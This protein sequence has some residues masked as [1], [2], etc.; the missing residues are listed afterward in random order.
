MRYLD[1][2][3]FSSWFFFVPRR[4]A[5]ISSSRAVVELDDSGGVCRGYTEL[6][7]KIEQRASKGTEESYAISS[8]VKRG[9]KPF[10]VCRQGGF[11]PPLR[12]K[13]CFQGEKERDSALMPRA[14][15][16][17]DN[18]RDSRHHSQRERMGPPRCKINE[19]YRTWICTHWQQVMCMYKFDRREISLRPRSC[20]SEKS[21]RFCRFARSISGIRSRDKI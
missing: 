8:L 6:S 16:A 3:A 10:R 7:P 15:C 11:D 2:P 5:L 14:S 1:L 13:P 21:A 19:L 17:V 12:V 20:A 18:K 4:G 9:W